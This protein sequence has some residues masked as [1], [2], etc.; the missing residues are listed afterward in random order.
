MPSANP[1]ARRRKL[2]EKLKRINAE[3]QRARGRA[4]Q[5]KRKRET[6]RKI[7]AGA[8]V[9]DWVARGELAEKRFKA[10]MDRFL[11]RPSDRSLFD[12]PPPAFQRLLD[13]RG[14]GKSHRAIAKILEAEGVPLAGPAPGPGRYKKWNHRAVGR[15]LLQLEGAYTSPAAREE[16]RHGSAE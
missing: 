5:E 11:K 15:L 6:R 4:A 9:L 12:L 8:M 10:D 16:V 2:E 3:L 13:L 14:E 7:L 1:E